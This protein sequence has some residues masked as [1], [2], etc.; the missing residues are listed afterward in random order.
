MGSHVMPG[1]QVMSDLLTMR[2]KNVI[3]SLI[4]PQ[5]TLIKATVAQVLESTEECEALVWRSTACGVLCVLRDELLDSYF[6][7][8]FCVKV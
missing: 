1:F 8:L 5:W 4:Q 7:R 2:E 3:Y 6:L